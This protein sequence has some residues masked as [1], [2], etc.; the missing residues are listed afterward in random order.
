MV[1][2]GDPKSVPEDR[3]EKEEMNKGITSVFLS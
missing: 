1:N 2:H 3:V